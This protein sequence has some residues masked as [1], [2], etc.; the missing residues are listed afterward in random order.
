MS[1]VASRRDWAERSVCGDMSFNI[2]SAVKTLDE[3]ILRQLKAAAPVDEHGSNQQEN[4]SK[5]K[6]YK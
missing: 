6:C 4:K 3:R 1:F 5:V 2:E